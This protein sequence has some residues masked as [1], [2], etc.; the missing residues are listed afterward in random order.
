[1][2]LPPQTQ[3]VPSGFPSPAAPAREVQFHD[4]EVPAFAEAELERLYGCVMTTVARFEIYEAAP[5][6]ST[7]V[8][9]EY[10]Q[11]TTLF[12][13]R[14]EGRRVTVYNEQIVLGRAEI[15]RFADAVFARYPGVHLI[16]F[17]A[18]DAPTRGIRYPLQRCACL[19]DIRLTLPDTADEYYAGLGVNLR[20]ALRRYRRQLQR[21]YP[22]FRFEVYDGD[23]ASE[24]QV[25]AIVELNRLRMREKGQS[26]Y[27]D[28]AAVRR[29]LRLVRKYGVVCA[30]TIDSRICG[31]VICMRVGS[32]YHM[33]VLAHDSR[34]SAYRLGKL[35][36]C[37]S[38]CHA[39]GQGGRQY[40]F[41]WG[42]YDYKF[43][44]QGRLK[45]LYRLEVYRS[46]LRLLANAPRVTRLAFAAVVRRLRLRVDSAQAGASRADRW[47]SSAAGVLRRLKRA[48]PRFGS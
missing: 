41:G 12:L 30:A 43:K 11:V 46:R 5:H 36:C 40:T 6:A 44:L 20:V 22:S 37:F 35:C 7:Y 16:S 17:Y 32:T 31:G 25:R 45:E 38:I 48:L 14:A 4:D 47:I 19:E 39:I 23:E 34:Y 13:F 18:V 15:N 9:R 26:S 29:L 1:M 10:G 21:D 24:E 42:R 33:V 27:Y 28:E 8:V 3:L 2:K